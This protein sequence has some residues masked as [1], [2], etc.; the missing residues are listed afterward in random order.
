VD[1]NH[2]LSWDGWNII[3]FKPNPDAYFMQNGVF[4]NLKWGTIN[5]FPITEQGWDVPKRYARG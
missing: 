3:E 5:V 1:N 4:K 2:S